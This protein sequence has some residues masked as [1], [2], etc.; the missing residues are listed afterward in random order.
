MDY[1][2]RTRL[3]RRHGANRL[4]Y[5]HPS[6]SARSWR[7]L[8]AAIHA[9]L[10]SA[11]VA[12]FDLHHWLDA[13]RLE[14]LVTRLHVFVHRAVAPGCS[15]HDVVLLA[16]RQTVSRHSETGVNRC[17]TLSEACARDAAGSLSAVRRRVCG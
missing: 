4:R 16:V 7:H 6:A 8:T 17:R 12:D 15:D 13:Y 11:P 14:P 9:R 10:Y 2:S 3:H 1:V 5:R